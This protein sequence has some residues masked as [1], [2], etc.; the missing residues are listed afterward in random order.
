MDPPASLPNNIRSRTSSPMNAVEGIP[1]DMAAFMQ[2]NDPSGRRKAVPSPKPPAQSELLR[3]ALEQNHITDAQDDVPMMMSSS[4]VGSDPI[5]P[6]GS[7]TM[8]ELYHHQLQRQRQPSLLYEDGSNDDVHFQSPPS[9]AMSTAAAR[10]PR[11]SSD[12]TSFRY[13]SV[14]TTSQPHDT[15]TNLK[16]DPDE[17]SS[18]NASS[19]NVLDH[20]PTRQSYPTDF[21][22]QD[23]LPYQQMMGDRYAGETAQDRHQLEDQHHEFYQIEQL[24]HEQHSRSHLPPVPTANVSQLRSHPATDIRPQPR[25]GP[26]KEP[27][28]QPVEPPM[29]R[30]KL[31]RRCLAQKWQRKPDK[32]TAEVVVYGLAEDVPSRDSLL[33]M[34]CPGCQV[35]L[36]VARTT[37]LI[38]CPNCE[39]VHPAAKCRPKKTAGVKSTNSIPTF[40]YCAFL[41]FLAFPSTVTGMPS[42][43]LHYDLTMDACQAMDV[44][45]IGVN[46]SQSANIRFH[47]QGTLGD[48]MELVRNTT[49]TSCVLGMGLEP[50]TTLETD[51]FHSFLYG[52][53]SMEILQTQLQTQGKNG[54]TMA[55]W[56]RHAGIVPDGTVQQ[57]NSTGRFQPLLTI[58]SSESHVANN[59]SSICEE[60]NVDFQLAFNDY[61]QMK[62]IYKTSDA[63]FSPCQQMIM[64]VPRTVASSGLAH[65]V[66]SLTN[67]RQEIF[68]NGELVGLKREPFDGNLGHWN[69]TSKLNFFSYP[70]V[71]GDGIDGP[72]KGHLFQF[73]VMPGGSKLGDVK[74]I[75]SEG[76]P[77]TNP[78]ALPLKAH[79][80]EDADQDNVLQK[81]ELNLIYLDGE[82]DLLLSALNL[83]HQAAAD[84]LLYITHFPSKGH[85][86]LPES[87]RN[88]LPSVNT[89]VLAGKNMKQLVYIPPLNEY[90]EPPGTI[91]TT[92]DYC[93]TAS[94]VLIHSPLQCDSATVSIVIE[95]VN[96]PP[97]AFAPPLHTVHEGI[98]E[99]FHSI[100]LTGSDVDKGDWVHAIQITSPPS[101]GQLYL[102]VGSFRVWDD[103]FHGTMLASINY[104]F[105]GDEG[106]V[107]YH[108][109]AHDKVILDRTSVFDYFSFRVQDTNGA[110]SK[111]VEAEIHVVP[112]IAPLLS[113]PFKWEIP[114]VARAMTQLFSWNDSSGLNRTCALLLGSLPMKGQ[115]MNGKSVIATTESIISSSSPDGAQLTFIANSDA[116]EAEDAKSVKDMFSF[117]VVALD[118]KNQVMSISDE[119]N[120]TLQIFCDIPPIYLATSQ[121][122]ISV[123]ASSHHI[124]NPCSGYSFNFSEAPIETCG[125]DAALINVHV[126]KTDRQ[127]DF[128]LLSLSTDNGLLTLNK[129]LVDGVYPINDQLVMRS[130]IQ[131]LIKPDE[132]GK[133]LAAVHF[134][135]EVVGE[136]KI[137]IVVENEHCGH[138]EIWFLNQD[139]LETGTDCLQ[140]E[141]VI[142]VD[143]QQHPGDTPE[144][145]YRDFPWIPLPFAIC[146][147]LIIKLRGKSR[148]ILLRH[149]EATCSLTS[150]GSMEAVKW[151]EHYDP[152]TGYYYYHNREDGEITWT[153]PLHEEYIPCS[154]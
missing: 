18:G 13:A 73:S 63:F 98:H 95:P 35:L 148:E 3:Q 4:V 89:P 60:A 26:P 42:P 62:L 19:H 23:I 78:F 22:S 147:L 67:F 52:S 86:R 84:L 29:P 107:G 37:L 10:L 105:L 45:S 40:L 9:V 141:L 144:F 34:E 75:I 111:E 64:D 126:S 80:L 30:T 133:I 94:N 36:Q 102:D 134:Q 47:N 69:P 25:P 97:T 33:E 150:E 101:L 99:E 7:T 38:E 113:V 79:I 110:W 14:S 65:L 15:R 6:Y 72:W 55:L 128:L 96:D 11:A 16:K 27:L 100:K 49:T 124:D 152:K 127:P 24:H 131:V 135:S 112:S 44:A 74:N 83:P 92:F 88:I 57:S 115:L 91:Y 82:V 43:L 125:S 21:D 5:H 143:V 146:M 41:L 108:F 77:P 28:A 132:I 106:Y 51:A 39:E 93:M 149:E 123:V 139:T 142:Q 1:P 59:P 120:V 85:L 20:V 109:T 76:L 117:R 61:H 130:T 2:S 54:V 12:D 138:R 137:H 31:G 17:S 81:I 90:S 58:S 66:I 114:P 32:T 71:T 129:D 48:G 56:F 103:L 118:A 53:Q 104:T 46:S 154:E 119:T 136:D 122:H 121:E 145:L 87:D 153:P 50:N 140:T 68:Y 116:C 151:T 70:D 8:H